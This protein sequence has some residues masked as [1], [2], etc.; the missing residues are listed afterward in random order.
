MQ[1]MKRSSVLALAILATVS[2]GA[3]SA[4]AA[5]ATISAIHGIPGLP[6][7]VQ[8]LV[9][10]NPVF[11]FDYQD[12]EGPYYVPADSYLIEI[13]LGGSVVLS[14][15]F[16]LAAG[17]DYTVIAHLLEGGAINL[18]LFENDRSPINPFSARLNVRHAADAPAVDIQLLQAVLDEE[19]ATIGPA[20]NGDQTGPIDL[21]ESFYQANI[22]AAGTE[23]LVVSAEDLLS[24]GQRHIVYAVGSL[25]GGTF[26]LLVQ[27][28]HLST[29]PPTDTALVS[30]LHGIPGLPE[31]VTVV[32]DGF[33]LFA[34]DFGDVVGPLTLPSG[35]HN[36]AVRLDGVTVLEEDVVLDPDGD[37]SVIAHLLEGSGI[38]LGVF[39]NDRSPLD[40]FTSRVTVRH[41][42][43]APAV[44]LQVIRALDGSEVTKVGP[45]SNGDQA[46]PFDLPS[47]TYTAN[48]FAAG[49]TDLVASAGGYLAGKNRYIVYA[50]GSLAGGT[51]QFLVQDD[52]IP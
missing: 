50:V 46:G 45:A 32:V 26:D 10:G 52:Y 12:I 2:L 9:N 11:S 1:I 18:A 42:A 15:T 43:D 20:A 24:R 27:R 22:F 3:A 44:D 33:P 30:V 25:A 48:L 39:V 13:S 29:L 47:E 8:V 14:E 23:N 19:V 41:A 16:D 31:P 4:P 7:P 40:P 5:T 35:P 21:P 36:L 37:Y 17:A 28:N 6:E 49:T 34:F 51:F 38:N